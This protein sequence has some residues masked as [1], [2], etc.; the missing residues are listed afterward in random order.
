MKIINHLDEAR[1]YLSQGKII[2]YPTEAVY[3]LGC[4][5]FNHQ[6][7]LHLL[8]IKQRDINKGLI[9]LINNWSQLP[10]LIGEVSDHLMEKVRATWPGP[11]TWVFPKAQSIPM[12]LS[13]CYPSIAIRMSA[14]P[15]AQQLCKAGP[16]ISTS[17]NRSGLEPAVDEQSLRAQFSVGIDVLIPGALG[18]ALRPSEIFDVFSGERLR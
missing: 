2:A 3:G 12:W 4:D 18:G 1:I 11:V 8:S 10:P 13:G 15:I 9:L 16:I 7:V 14:H 6:A 5:P 17:A